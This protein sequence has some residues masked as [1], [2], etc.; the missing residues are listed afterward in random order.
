LF[1]R[2]PGG[3]FLLQE[4]PFDS[5]NDLYSAITQH[6][7]V[8][9]IDDLNLGRLMVVCREARFESGSA[10]LI[11]VDEGGQ[12]VII[13]V[14][15]GNENPDARRV[16]AQMLDYGAQLW[17]TSRE[18]FETR[19][20]IPWLQQNWQAP[21]LPRSLIEAAVTRFELDEIEAEQFV[22]TLTA[23]LSAGT[24]YYVVVARSLPPNLQK[25]LQYV[26]E[27]SNLPTAAV[28]VDYFR[29]PAG[30]EI[31]APRVAFCS[32]SVTTKTTPGKTN[33]Q[34]FLEEVGPASDFWS[35]F[36]EFLQSLGG[37]F[38]WGSKGFSYRIELEGKL[39]TV[40]WG[41]PRTVWWLKS[42]SLGDEIEVLFE[43]PAT[44]PEPLR[45]AI[46]QVMRPL[47]DNSVGEPNE[48]KLKYI[49][50]FV[51]SGLDER[52]DERLRTVLRS[53]WSTV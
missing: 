14:K 5:E 17:R 27:V 33:P 3:D 41:Y 25:V 45:E 2:E 18:D 48:G 40:L 16:I 31:M 26:G 30:R 12:L 11:L 21:S 1:I 52:S 8:M 22:S 10:D 7:E 42:K 51:Q 23:N 29:D 43:A 38:Y 35:E 34:H 13:E 4:S 44:Y 28:V 47:L 50:L 24:F 32:T 6:P 19:T 46:R 9:P 20:A 53:L 39:Y 36:F 37:H 15:R 49:R